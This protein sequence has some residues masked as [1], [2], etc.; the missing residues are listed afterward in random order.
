MWLIWSAV[1]FYLLLQQTAQTCSNCISLFRQ[2][3]I[4]LLECCSTMHWPVLNYV[5]VCLSVCHIVDIYCH[6][7]WPC[8]CVEDH[9]ILLW[10]F[11]LFRTPPLEVTELNSI[12]LCHIFVTSGGHELQCVAISNFS[13]FFLR[14]ISPLFD[15]LSVLLHSRR[16]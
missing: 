14:L 1:H 3:S 10:F 16:A 9:Y 15:T 4:N 11:L 13:N 6:V 7:G 12:K 8:V 5:S 2:R